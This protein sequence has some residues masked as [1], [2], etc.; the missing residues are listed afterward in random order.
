MRDF[1]L[2]TIK[3]QFFG[4]NGFM[5]CLA[6]QYFYEVKGEPA[7][8]EGSIPPHGR[9]NKRTPTKIS[10]LCISYS[11]SS[12]YTLSYTIYTLILWDKSLNLVSLVQLFSLLLSSHT[13]VLNSKFSCLGLLI[14][15]KNCR[16]TV[17]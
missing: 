14:F 3:S 16:T 10:F 4:I 9:R 13:L 1:K 7:K 11:T 5:A 17:Y 6:P 15:G 8:V 2:E 12:I